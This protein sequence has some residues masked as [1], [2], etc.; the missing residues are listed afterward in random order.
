[1]ARLKPGVTLA[2]AQAA[3][4]LAAEQ[5]KRKFPGATGPQDGFTAEPLRDTVIGDVRK[6]LLIL[7]GAVGMVLFIACANVANCCWCVRPCA[8]AKSLSR[9]DG[10]GKRTHHPATSHRSVLL[11]LGGG[12]S[13]LILGYFGVHALLTMNPG[14]IPLIGEQGA[15]I[16]LDR[17]VL[18][19]TLLVSLATGVLFGLIPVFER[20]AR[21]S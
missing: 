17:R 2:Q 8:N 20:L 13:G 19:F 16:T 10:R 4:K 1:M 15:A 21:R 7:L 18:V 3:T 9:G 14:N 11:S 12:A 5:Y 6:S